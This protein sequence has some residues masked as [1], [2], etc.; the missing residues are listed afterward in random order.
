MSETDARLALIQDWVTRDLRLPLERIEPAS[1]DASFRRY[2]RAFCGTMTLHRHGCAAGQGGVRPYLKVTALLE[3]GRARAARVR[4]RCRPRP[5][6]AGGPGPTPY[7]QQLAAGGDPTAVRRCAG[8]AGAISRCAGCG[9]AAELA[10]YDRERAR[11][12]NRPD[13]RVVP[14]A[15]PGA[16]AHARRARRCSRA[17]TSSSS[18]RRWRSRRCSCIATITRAISW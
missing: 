13:A 16:G 7:L 3:P 14:R 1:S 2:F 6:A 18:A 8:G 12:R 9:A 17:P 10:P 15:P 11:A 4:R 5:A